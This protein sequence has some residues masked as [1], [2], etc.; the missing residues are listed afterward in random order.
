MAE[1]VTSVVPDSALQTALHKAR[2]RLIPL[3]AAC[4]LI[5]YMDRVNISFAAESM[6]R[7]LHFTPKIYGLGAGLFFL[8]YALCEIPS[9]RLLLR[10]GARRWIARI[11]LTWG[12]LAAAMVFI[13]TP[14][15]FYGLRLLL[16]CAE[17]GYFPGAIFYLSLWFPP[18]Q[19]ARSISL[20]YIAFPLSSVVMGG[21]AGVLLRQDG[22]LGLSGWQ[23]LFLVEALPAILMSAVIWFALPDGPAKAPWLSEPEREALD[24]ALGGAQG[25]RLEAE[26]AAAHG[27]GLSQALRSP[28]VWALGAFYLVMLGSLY[29]VTFSLPLVL[30][31][32]TGWQMGRVGGVVAAFGAVDA[33]AML[34]WAR[35]SD[36]HRERRWHVAGPMLLMACSLGVAGSLHLAGWATVVAL[37]VFTAAYCA[38][39]GPI[40]TVGVS[41]LS[42]RAAAVGIAAINTCGIIGGFLGPYWMGWMREATG[43]YALG[44]GAL[45]LPCLLAAGLILRL[46]PA[47]E[48]AE[49]VE[50]IG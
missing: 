42:G 30:R 7:Q 12:L 14:A 19:R 26:R 25:R 32:A 44:I 33:A 39:Q 29:S 46:V 6:N 13:H 50:A 24:E 5:A 4:Y 9:N 10:F 22:K 17:A 35:H 49:R 3:L 36:L 27:D 38:M 37:L 21:L 28:K 31:S 16:G 20:F 43:G 15:S 41:A 48:R 1:S 2:W 23:W 18:E 34:L 8:S 40:L 45:A 47:V 11:M